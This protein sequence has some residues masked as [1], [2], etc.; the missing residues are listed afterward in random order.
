MGD[1]GLRCLSFANNKTNTPL[2]YISCIPMTLK[3]QL[4]LRRSKVSMTALFYSNI[5]S[6]PQQYHDL[7]IVL[8]N[9]RLLF[10]FII[11]PKQT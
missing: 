1:K 11:K 8:Q 10:I 4:L 6:Q 9:R 2:V 5:L 7:Y 3:K